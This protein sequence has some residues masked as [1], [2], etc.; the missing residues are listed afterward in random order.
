MEENQQ[1][2]KSGSDEHLDFDTWQSKTYRV[3]TGCGNIYITICRED[4]Q[5]VKTIIHRKSNCRCDLTFFDSLNRQTTFMTN[6][7][8]EQTITDLLGNDLPKEGHYCH[9]YNI[10][11]KGKMKQGLMGAYS[12]SDAIARALKRE[13]DEIPK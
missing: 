7:E 2:Y 12:C 6:R 4:G 11:V 8:L 10:T 5:I 3:Y 9:N 1:V 13:I